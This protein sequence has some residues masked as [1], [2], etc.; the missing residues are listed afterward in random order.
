MTGGAGSGS[1]GVTGSAGNLLREPLVPSVGYKR[2]VAVGFGELLRQSN[3]RY[4][5]HTSMTRTNGRRPCETDVPRATR[6]SRLVLAQNVPWR[7]S[8]LTTCEPIGNSLAHCQ[9]AAGAST[10]PPASRVGY[11]FASSSTSL[12]TRE[13]D[14]AESNPEEF[15]SMS[16]RVEVPAPY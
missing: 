1:R 3:Q 10:M 11:D 2:L 4:L 12:L 13:G 6:T 9:S 16:R 7:P 15:R 8:L 14:M 5:T